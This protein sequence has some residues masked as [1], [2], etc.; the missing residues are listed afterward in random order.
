[1]KYIAVVGSSECSP[2]IGK[3]AYEVGKEIALRKAVLVCGGLGG[4][5]EEACRGAWEEGGIT[6]GILPGHQ[7]RGNP[8]LSLALPTGLGEAR[9]FLVVKVSDAVI[10]VG[11]EYGTLSEIAL[12]L[13]MGR[14]VVGIKTWEICKEGVLDKGIIRAKTPGE[15]VKLA[16]GQG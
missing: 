12:A 9:N 7:R 13:K 14:K 4:V 8:Y 15:A 10:A 3:I 2:E 6:L 5:M 11:G 1:V 16:L